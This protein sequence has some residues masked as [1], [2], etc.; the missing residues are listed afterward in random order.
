MSELA[1]L[2]AFER[3]PGRSVYA[4]IQ[5]P[6]RTWAGGVAEDE[7]R[8]AASLAK[9]PLAM[10]VEPQLAVMAAS[11]VGDLVRQEDVSILHALDR[12]RIMQPRELLALM[13]SASDPACARWAL[14]CTDLDAVTAAARTAGAAMTEIKPDEDF[15]VLG[16]TTARDAV[17]LMRAVSDPHGFPACADALHHSITNSRIPLGVTAD[18]IA[19]AH[20]TGTLTGVAHDV[21]H[22]ACNGGDVWIAFLCEEEHDTLVTGYDMGICTRDLLEYVGLQVVRTRSVIRRS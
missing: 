4:V 2:Q 6:E 12:D 22:L 14:A 10:A 19:V 7:L 1:I 21:A 13:L 11:R 3:K 18:D 17:S 16:R 9:I 8:P 15:G 20:K 5:T